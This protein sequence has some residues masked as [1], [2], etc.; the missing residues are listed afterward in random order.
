MSSSPFLLRLLTK[1]IDGNTGTSDNWF[2]LEKL[3]Q[4]I[5]S[6]TATRA[7]YYRAYNDFALST[8]TPDEVNQTKLG[9]FEIAQSDLEPPTEKTCLGMCQIEDL[10]TMKPQSED[11]MHAELDSRVY[12]LIQDFD[13]RGIGHSK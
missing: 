5:Q 6:T 7:G 12:R 13:P 10:A 11:N 2:C 1:P 3:P 9:N 8:K 4:L